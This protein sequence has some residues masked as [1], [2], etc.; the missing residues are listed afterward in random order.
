[1]GPV[2]EGC[3]VGHRDNDPLNDGP[4]NLILLDCATHMRRLN[5]RPEVRAKARESL[6]RTGRGRRELT[7]QKKADGIRPTVYVWDCGACGAEF[8]TETD[9]CPKCGGYAI[10]RRAIY[11]I[12]TGETQEEKKEKAQDAC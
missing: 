5:G 4:Y 3:F 11:R 7:G 1:H 12:P 10:T 2:P 8:T 9:R 6:R